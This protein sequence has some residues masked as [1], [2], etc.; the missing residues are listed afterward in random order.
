MIQQQ[1]VD[2]AITALV[3]TYK[4]RGQPEQRFDMKLQEVQESITHGDE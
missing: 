2:P 1:G 3:V 4:P